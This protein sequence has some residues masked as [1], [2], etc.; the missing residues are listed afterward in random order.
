MASLPR[1]RYLVT[2]ATARRELE[3]RGT[4]GTRHVVVRIGRPRRDSEPGDTWVCPYDITGLSKPYRRWAFGIDGVQ[5]LTLAYHILPAELDRLA[6]EEGGG[7]FYFLGE[8]GIGFGDGCGIL[9]QHALNA[10]SGGM[11]S[12]AA[13]NGPEVGSARKR[14]RRT[15]R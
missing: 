13:G 3:F 9:V 1:T 8:P 10:G 5:A 2:Q 11:P 7:Q 14:R 4:G 6:R 12:H 15:E